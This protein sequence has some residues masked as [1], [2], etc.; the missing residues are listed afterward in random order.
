MIEAPYLS[1]SKEWTFISQWQ[2]GKKNHSKIKPI[3]STEYTIVYRFILTC[4]S[5]CIFYKTYKV[6]R[7]SCNKD[8]NRNSLSTVTIKELQ[9]E[10]SLLMRRFML[11]NECVQN[12]HATQETL[13]AIWSK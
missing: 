8:S 7:L 2:W 5:E 10:H 1:T 6:S 13:Q 11:Q 12:N 9:R 3:S 4:F